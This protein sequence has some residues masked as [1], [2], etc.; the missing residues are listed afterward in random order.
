VIRRF[1]L[2][3]AALALPVL[4]N[5]AD[6]LQLDF[7]VHFAKSKTTF[8]Y[9]NGASADT[10]IQQIRVSWYERFAPGLEIGMF[11][12]STYLTQTNNTVTA[13]LEPDGYHAGIGLRSVL[14]EAAPLQ[15]IARATYTY[16]RV[17]HEDAN[18]SVTLSWH[19]PELY[20]GASVAATN[21]LR[22]YGGATWG[23]IDGQERVTGAAARTTDFDRNQS[24]GGF[25]GLELIV[26]RDGYIGVETHAGATR[27]GEIYFKKS[28]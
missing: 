2:A 9:A 22:V 25:F 5:A 15:L 27:G 14:W 3:L 24:G 12:G 1:A 8:D 11:G 20:L 28:F 13:G 10:T 7:A 21:R 4:A 17:Q 26:E 6:D 23:A 18:Q 16:Q 19:Q